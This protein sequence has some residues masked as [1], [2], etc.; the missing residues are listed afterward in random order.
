MRQPPPPISQEGGVDHS[1]EGRRAQKRLSLLAKLGVGAGSRLVVG[2]EE[3]GRG[4]SNC[5]QRGRD[6]GSRKWE[7]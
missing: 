2:P 5:R 3:E 6:P 4:V 1:E 7:R